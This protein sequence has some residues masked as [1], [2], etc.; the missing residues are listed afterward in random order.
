MAQ[1][2]LRKKSK[3]TSRAKAKTPRK[4]SPSGKKAGSSPSKNSS[5]TKLLIVESPAKVR[6]IKKFLGSDFNIVASRGHVRDLLKTGERKMGIDVNGDFQGEYGEIPTKKKAISELRRAASTADEIYLAPDPDREGEAI[7]WHIQEILRNDGKHGQIFRVSFN[8][9]TPRAVR[10]SLENPG[11]IDQEKVDAQET[12]RKLD[13][14]VGFKLSGEILWNKVAF[15]LSA[16]R[17][18]SVALRLISEREAEVIAFEPIEY[19][20]IASSLEKP[21]VDP[22]F[23]AKLHR[24]EGEEP[25]IPNEER[26]R[27]LAATIEGAA[28]K[29]AKVERRERRRRPPAPF[30]TST[31]QQECSTKLRYGAKR[32]M[33]I[34]QSLYEGVNLGQGQGNVG[35]ITYMRTDSVRLAPEAVSM[36]RT[37]I[38]K[39]YSSGHLPE[40]PPTYKSKDNIQD[41]H[42]AIRPTDAALTPDEIKDRIKPEQLAIYTLIWRRYLASQMTPAVFD[43][44]SVDIA[45]GPLTLRATGSVMKFSGFLEVYQEKSDEFIDT[46]NSTSASGSDRL[47]PNLEKDDPVFPLASEATPTGVLPEQHFTQPPPRYTEAALV[48][49]LEEDGVGRPSTYATILDTLEK[50]KYVVMERKKRQFTPTS[51]GIEVNNLLIQGFPEEIDVKFTAKIESALDDI[52]NGEIPWLP[53]LRNFYDQFDKKI[54]AAKKTLPNLK[55]K[56]EPIG[57]DCP[58]CGSTLVK[59]FSRNGWFISCS[60]YPDCKHSESI[61]EEGEEAE[62]DE[63]LAQI[64]EKAPPC[65]ECG[66]PMRVKR[67]PYGLYLC[68]S[69]QPKEHKTRKLNSAGEPVEKPVS[70]GIS[71][72][73]KDCDGELVSRRSRRT[74]KIFYGC[75][76]FPKCKYVVWDLPVNRSCP[77][78]DHPHVTLKTTKKNG[79]QL[80]CPVNSCDYKEKAPPAIAVQVGHENGPAANKNAEESP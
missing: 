12:R 43:Q 66:E 3:S 58:E 40:S 71:C 4:N 21:G 36:A 42:E 38:G 27:E 76:Q 25:E 62:T 60:K 33:S 72:A 20:T 47:L 2:T 17:V 31:L 18:Q 11:R 5:A 78:C 74:G 9:I 13:R 55:T 45:A 56:T 28:L 67:G 73:R 7:A 30:I 53:M 51:L 8:E 1:K 26:A 29:V 34:A 22:P 6:T 63:E 57:R 61:V 49:E 23:E 75:N 46:E 15:G 68:C 70:T 24:I 52:E 65:E 48:K 79:T 16:G 54:Q 80:V 37:Y 14:I 77:T 19:W 59:K 32:T 69:A 64:E 50:R 44:T 35:L 10:E 39:N 41:A